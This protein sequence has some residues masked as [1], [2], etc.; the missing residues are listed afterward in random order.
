MPHWRETD[1]FKTHYGNLYEVIDL[2][3]RDIESV[4]R[5]ITSCRLILSTSLHGLIVAHAYAIPALHL[6]HGYIDTDGFKFRDYYSSVGIEP[7]EGFTNIDEILALSP[8]GMDDFFDA[9]W[10]SAL[11]QTDLNELRRKLLRAAPFPLL[12]HYK[13]LCR[14]N[15][16]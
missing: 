3:T 12:D 10:Q 6:K 2:R 15:E 5:R 11:P 16:N 14:S 1:Y 9:H 4:V 13:N 7:Y 8:E